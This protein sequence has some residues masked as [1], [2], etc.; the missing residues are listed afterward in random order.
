MMYQIFVMVSFAAT[1][2]IAQKIFIDKVPGYFDLPSCAEVP[3]SVIVRDMESGCGDNG[4]TTSYSCFCTASS[5]K[6]KH[7]IST[8]ITSRCS[9]SA[10]PAAS[11]AEYIFEEY[12]QIRINP[13]SE[14]VHL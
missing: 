10:L 4:R 2:V 5:S 6:I 11:S 12:C 7:I 3:L 9:A 1:A 13:A 8:E 14:F